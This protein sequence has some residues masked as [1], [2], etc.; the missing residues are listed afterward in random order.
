M[1]SKI[2]EKKGKNTKSWLNGLVSMNQCGKRWTSCAKIFLSFLP[3]SNKGISLFVCDS[4]PRRFWSFGG[5]GSQRWSPSLLLRNRCVL[6]LE[7]LSKR[8]HLI[9]F[10]SCSINRATDVVELIRRD[11][12]LIGDK[13]LSLAL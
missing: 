5:Y 10:L 4:N 11:A 7:L 6:K 8:V 3:H 1:P 13:E 9:F 12:T 2:F